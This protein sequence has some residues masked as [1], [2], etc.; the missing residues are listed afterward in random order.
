MKVILKL[1]ESNSKS[2]DRYNLIRG[3]ENWLYKIVIKTIDI[4]TMI[5][6]LVVFL[7]NIDAPNCKMEKPY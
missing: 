7:E 3:S 1:S 6:Y 2:L 4:E 5:K